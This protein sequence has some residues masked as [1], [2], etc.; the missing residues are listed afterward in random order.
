MDIIKRSEQVE[1][2]TWS[3]AHL[4]KWAHVE[5][6]RLA[7]CPNVQKVNWSDM[8]ISN[9]KSRATGHLVVC[10]SDH[11][12]KMSTRWRREVIDANATIV[13]G[14]RRW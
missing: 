9:V 12:P 14:V 10:P 3:T 7:T 4:P 2:E 1:S 8:P 5:H 6:E 13:R 11:L